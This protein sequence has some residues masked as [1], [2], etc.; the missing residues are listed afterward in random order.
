MDKSVLICCPPEPVA[1]KCMFQ[2]LRFAHTLKCSR[3]RID[4]MK[5][6]P[7]ISYREETRLSVFR[8]LLDRVGNQEKG[9]QE[10]VIAEDVF[11]FVKKIG[12]KPR[13]SRT[14]DND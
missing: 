14:G 8:R 2:R 9:E 1:G 4:G 11:P 3:R 12:G 13:I 7:H 10:P 5:K 6:G